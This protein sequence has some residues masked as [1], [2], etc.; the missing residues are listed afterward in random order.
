LCQCTSCCLRTLTVTGVVSEALALPIAVRDYELNGT[1]ADSLGGPSLVSD[2][3]TLGP[4]TYSFG[5]NQGL[6][7]S[8]ALNPTNYSIDVY[9]EFDAVSG[10][11]KIMD[12]QD[13]ANDNWL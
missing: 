5:A 2:G 12:F 6:N 9:F 13:R 4:T 10:Y 7:L 1:L 3:G 8:N 11:R